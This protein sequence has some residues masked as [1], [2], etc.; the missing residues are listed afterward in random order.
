MYLRPMQPADTRERILTQMF[1]DIRKNGFQGLR[2]DKV[3]DEMDVTKGALYHY[4]ANKQA[5]GVA[6]IDEIIRPN[7]LRFYRE[8]DRWEG[9]PLDKLQEHLQ[10]LSDKA[11]DDEVVLGCPLN[12]LMQEMSPL[13]EDFRLRLK[14]I[15]DSIHSSIAAALTR[16]QAAGLVQ[17]QVRPEQAAQ[18]FFACIEG[19]STLAKVRKDTATFSS[20]MGLLAQF[21]NTLRI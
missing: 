13:N 15:V 11:T 16:G 14:S 21:L 20:I 4:F 3:I 19:A 17:A 18:F 2:A 1:L 9:H 8:L 7:Y 6:V 5:I 12:N 10:F